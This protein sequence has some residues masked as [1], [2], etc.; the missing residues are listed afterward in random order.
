MTFTYQ[1]KAKIKRDLYTECKGLANNVQVANKAEDHDPEMTTIIEQLLPFIK[2][3]KYSFVT[4]N[5]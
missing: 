2:K 5:I 1:V 4:L 3:V